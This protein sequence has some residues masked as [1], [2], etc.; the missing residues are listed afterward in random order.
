MMLAILGILLADSLQR[1]NA[2]K[3]FLSFVI[4]VVGALFFIVFVPPAWGAVAVIAPAALLGGR[5]G[6]TLARQLSNAA[7]RRLVVVF[8]TAVGLYLL[9]S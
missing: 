3:G 4:N 6:V 5:T 1:L 9:V 8:G 7:L 2:L